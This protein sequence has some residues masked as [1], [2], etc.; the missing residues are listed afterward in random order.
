[1]DAV[2]A[3]VLHARAYRESSQLVDLLSV[4]HGR[5]GV[6]T[7][8]N[9][10]SKRGQPLQP[11]RRYRIALGGRGELRRA[12][13]VEAIGAPCLLNGRALYA[14]L[15][16]NE[17]LVRLLH[18]DLPVPDVVELYARALAQLAAGAALEPVLRCFEKQLLDELGYGHRYG[19]TVEG[20]PVLAAALYTFEP[21]RGVRLAGAG[22]PAERCFSG[23][24]LQ[25]LEQDGFAA[26]ANEETL[27]LALRDAKRLMRAALAPHLGDRPLHSRALFRPAR[28]VTGD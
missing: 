10:G 22:L 18:R 23:V 5:I 15:Y 6:L 21:E 1:M 7:R 26:L 20:E 17:L 13:T 3:Y 11:F 14:A 28:T 27:A 12:G 25:A 8:G 9:R 4:E 16:L 2:E 19:E 24:A